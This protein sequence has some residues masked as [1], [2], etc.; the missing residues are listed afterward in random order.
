MKHPDNDPHDT[1]VGKPAPG[2]NREDKNPGVTDEE[3]ET[4]LVTVPLSEYEELVGKAAEYAEYKDLYL[5][6]AADLDNYRKRTARERE[7][8]VCFANERLVHDLL[9][10]LDNL[11]RALEAE[12]PTPA[13]MSI[14]EGVRMVTDQLKGVLEK[15]GLE[16]L[17]PVGESFDPNIHEAIGVLPSQHHEEGTVIN[18]LQRGYTFRGKVVR[19]SMVH[20]SGGK[21]ADPEKG[22][23]K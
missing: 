23:E 21:S 9:P 10:I 7:D 3:G 22:E 14:L 12:E 15:C 6:A 18:E 16:S 19:P 1:A 17:S 2:K 20:V 11:D 5:R 8:L 13:T 4:P